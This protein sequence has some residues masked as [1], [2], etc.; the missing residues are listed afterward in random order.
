MDDYTKSLSL[1][2]GNMHMPSET[3][4][5]KNSSCA[6]YFFEEAGN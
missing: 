6:Q 5:I 4:F 3:A 1:N 2:S